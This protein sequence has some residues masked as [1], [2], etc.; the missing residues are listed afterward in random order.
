MAT[1]F[2]IK[3]KSVRVIENGT[4]VKE[5]GINGLLLTFYHPNSSEELIIVTRTFNLKDDKEL[6]YFKEAPPNLHT[7]KKIRVEGSVVFDIAL[8]STRQRSILVK[9]FKKI[10]RAIANEIIGK[11]PGSSIISGAADKVLGALFDKIETSD[12]ITRIG[13]VCWEIFEN[14]P[15][16]DLPL[17]LS[18]PKEIKIHRFDQEGD[19]IIKITRTLKKGDNNCSVV[20]N[21]QKIP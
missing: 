15:D 10:G 18:V 8:T 20:L 19:K 13:Y 12:K 7:L 2:G 14:S 4:M 6:D 3:L 11:I 17:T 9:V 21:L 1:T 16:G 5:A